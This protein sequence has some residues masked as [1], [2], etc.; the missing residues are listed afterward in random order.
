MIATN[1]STRM[2]TLA[3]GTAIASL[4][5]SGCATKSA[6]RADFSA[7]RSEVALQKGK[8]SEAIAHAEAAVLAEP[9]NAAYRAML[10]A[11][12]MESGRFLSAR[13]SFDDALTLGDDSA[14]TA[15]GF[16]LASI[17]SGDN[18]AALEVLEDWQDDIPAADLG[19][20][21]AL[22]GNTPQAVHI[23]S[24]AVRGGDN[25]PKTR[26]NL[27]YA[28][29]LNGNW[30]GARIMAAED[31]PLDQ[32]DARMARWGEMAGPDQAQTRVASLLGT[33]AV[34]DG[35]QPAALALA[36]H[37]SHEQLAAEAAAHAPPVPEAAPQQ[38]AEAGSELPALVADATSQPAAELA[39]ATPPVAPPADFQS[40]FAS[41]APAAVTPMQMMEAAAEF[42]S[43]PV[44]QQTPTR[45]GAADPAPAKA[46]PRVASRS[47]EQAAAVGGSH[48]VQLGSFS[49]EAGARR[50]WGIYA[51]RYPQLSDHQMVITRAVV[52]GKT[53][54][55]VSAGGMARAEATG[56]C[57]AVKRSGEGC[58]AWA[59]GRPMRG[60]T[61]SPAIRMASR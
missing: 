5:V 49:S 4:A 26:Q 1:R 24:N 21:L 20:A 28:L 7:G 42:V 33:T 39:I 22:A 54:F 25:T 14:R 11:A 9:R 61:D 37:P 12:Y 52:R 34:A 19:L 2:L 3:A 27:A 30:A 46:S 51:K 32:L 18:G 38:I 60:A 57:S 43:R 15:L 16:A 23:L 48:L 55:R 47:A 35:G 45:L 59:E 44:V 53:Y 10:G 40:A 17:G 8:V 6:P 41:P 31:V 36:N 50:A 58:H 13:T 56:I 29:A